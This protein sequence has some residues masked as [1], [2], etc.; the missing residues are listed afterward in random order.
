MIIT[1][2]WTKVT[3]YKLPKEIKTNKTTNNIVLF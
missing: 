1:Y 3:Q 2:T